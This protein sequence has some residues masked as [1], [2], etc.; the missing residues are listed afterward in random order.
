MAADINEFTIIRLGREPIV[1]RNPNALRSSE[2]AEFRFH[3]GGWSVFDFN[4]FE[5]IGRVTL[6]E[7]EPEPDLNTLLDKI[8]QHDSITIRLGAISASS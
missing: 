1:V 5:M 7:N 4:C 2:P 3:Q 6:D 8:G